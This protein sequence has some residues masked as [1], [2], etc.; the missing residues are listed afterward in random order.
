M[1]LPGSPLN[2]SM[3]FVSQPNQEEN[4]ILHVLTCRRALMGIIRQQG[5]HAPSNASPPPW[6]LWC[7][8]GVGGQSPTGRMV[9]CLPM[10]KAHSEAFLE[11]TSL[12]ERRLLPFLRS[13]DV[14]PA[15]P[16]HC[17]L[18]LNPS[19]QCSVCWE[20]G[21]SRRVHQSCDLQTRWLNKKREMLQQQCFQISGADVGELHMAQHQE[22]KVFPINHPNMAKWLHFT[23]AKVTPGQP[24]HSSSAHQ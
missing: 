1:T 18:L 11:T 8:I 16:L 21:G 23:S 14:L 7:L 22:E 2:G 24:K 15:C 10:G 17:L 12:L 6:V 19:I 9:W 3:K 4:I 13:A 20:V 5:M